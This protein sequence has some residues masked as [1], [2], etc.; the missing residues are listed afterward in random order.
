MLL[1]DK[2]AVIT[3]SGKSI[4]REIAL[5][6]AREGAKIVISD[7]NAADGE[8]TK[9]D[10]IAQGGQAIFVQTDVGCMDSVA[11]M[12]ESAVQAFGK[13]DIVVPNASIT[14][15]KGILELSA[16]EWERTLKVNLTGT[17]FTVKAVLPHMIKQN[18]GRIVVISSGSALTGSGGGPH[19]AATKGGQNSMVRNFAREFGPMGITTN[20]VAPRVIETDMLNHLYPLGPLRDAVVEKIP[21]RRVGQPEDIAALTVFLASEKAGYINGQIILSDGGRTFA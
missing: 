10:I 12:V 1:A 15:L 16:E 19:Y 21:V 3:G 18:Y 13:I 9:N 2:V 4:G 7:I 17:F 5:S 14:S 8:Q 20:A 11:N 6:M